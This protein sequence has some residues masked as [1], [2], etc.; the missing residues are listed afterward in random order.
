MSAWPALNRGE[1]THHL[2]IHSLRDRQA[3]ISPQFRMF[4]VFRGDFIF[5]APAESD[6]CFSA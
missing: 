1:R 6:P 4:G 3:S 5:L 2:V